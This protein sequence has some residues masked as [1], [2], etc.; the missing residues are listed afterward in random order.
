MARSVI[1][2]AAS[3]KI[4]GSSLGECHGTSRF[5]TVTTVA[6]MST[7][8]SNEIL[9]HHAQMVF[10]SRNL[11]QTGEESWR[12]TIFSHSEPEVDRFSWGQAGEQQKWKKFIVKDVLEVNN[13]PQV[14]SGEH[15]TRRVFL[16]TYFIL[17]II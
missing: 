11:I 14:S 3:G 2:K 7:T 15:H 12:E 13:K 6:G 10:V 4:V 9:T 5:T 1:K 17:D 16:L 8:R